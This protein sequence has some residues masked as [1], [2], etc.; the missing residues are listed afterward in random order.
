MDIARAIGRRMGR[1][2]AHVKPHNPLL[3]PVPLHW[4]RHLMRRYNQAEELAKWIAFY[5]KLDYIPDA[6]RRIKATH[7]LDNFDA[8]RRQEIVSDAIAANPR[9]IEQLKGRNVVLIDDVLTTGA[10]LESCTRALLGGGAAR[11][12]IMVLARARKEY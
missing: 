6:L 11:V 7:S 8:E 2:L 10:T 3:V 9:G 1:K 5:E 12:D 4:R